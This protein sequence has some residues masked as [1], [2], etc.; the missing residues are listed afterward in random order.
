MIPA[1]LSCLFVL[2]LYRILNTP[3]DG[4]ASLANAEDEASVDVVSQRLGELQARLD[5]VTASMG[6]ACHGGDEA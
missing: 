6:D 3:D 2:Y 5:R 4:S 1:V